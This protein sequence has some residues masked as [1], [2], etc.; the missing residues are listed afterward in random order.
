MWRHNFAAYVQI[1]LKTASTISTSVV[2][3]KLAYCNSLYCNLPDSVLNHHQLIQNNLDHAVV[4]A[5]K[6]PHINPSQIFTLA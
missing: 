4:N 3:S 2:H 6:S 5:P 1:N